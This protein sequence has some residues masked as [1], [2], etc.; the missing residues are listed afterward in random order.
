MLYGAFL[1]HLTNQLPDAMQMYTD[2]SR[3]DAGV[4]CAMQAEYITCSARL[5]AEASIF[6][7]ELFAKELTFG[8][9]QSSFSNCRYKSF[10]IHSGF[11]SA[12]DG[13]QD[14]ATHHP[15]VCKIIK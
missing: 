12:L 2:M 6:A 1:E 13:V 9:I 3:S 7:A 8:C 14:I 10:V 5:S 11:R 4:G 15:I